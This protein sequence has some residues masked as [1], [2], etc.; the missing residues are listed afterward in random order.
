MREIITLQVG[1][2]GNQIGCKFWDLVLREHAANNKNGN[3]DEAMSTF[4]RNT[5][6]K[7]GREL[8]VGSKIRSLKARSVLIDMEE[9]VLNSLLKG[10]MGEL[11]DEKQFLSDVSG[12]GNN[13]AHGHEVYGAKYESELLDKVR[14]EAERCDSLQSFFLIHSLGGGTGA[15]LGTYLLE[16]LEDYFPDVYRFT[17]SVFPSDDDDVVTSPYNSVL[18]LRSLIESADCVL[19]IENQALLDICEKAHR[20]VDKSKFEKEKAFDDMNLICAHLLSD[21]TASMRFEGSLN[22]DLNEITMNLVPFPRLHFTVGSLSPLETRLHK[23][24]KLLPRANDQMFRDVFG[25][26]YHLMRADPRQGSYLACGLLMRG[27]NMK[28]SDA[29][30]N[31]TNLQKDIDMVKWNQEGFKVGLCNVPPYG[32]NSSLLCLANNSCITKTFSAMRSRFMTLWKR[33]VYV[34]H[35]TNYTDVGVFKDSLKELD[36]LIGEYRSI[37]LYP[38]LPPRF[39]PIV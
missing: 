27:S 5:K 38:S 32:M 16:L 9:G 25:R 12:S 36:E 21:L 20:S 7:S 31:L 30:R 22:V 29:N 3:F 10:P 28:I 11:F 18:A 1:Q 15:G 33:K 34:H 13:W 39:S 8:S 14:R 23:Q 24:K 37:Q 35:Y 19:P 2:C 17:V 4:F 26:N 6:S